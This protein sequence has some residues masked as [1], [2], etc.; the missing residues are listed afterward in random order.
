MYLNGFGNHHQ[1]EA[2]KG[3]LPMEQNSPQQC[4]FGLYAEQLSGTAFTRQR[5]MNFYS[6]LYRILPSVAAGSFQL[7]PQQIVQPYIGKQ[8]PDPQRWSPMPPSKKAQDFVDSLYHVAGHDTVNVFLYHCDKTMNMR[9]FADNDGELLIVPYQ[10]AIRL[11]TELGQLSIEPG[12]IAVIPRGIKFRV[13]LDTPSAA[14]YVCENMAE[15]LKLPQLG[16]IGANGLAHARHF[17]YPV[18]AYEDVSGEV[19]LICKSGQNCWQGSLGQSPLNVVAWHGNYAPY[20]YHLSLYNTINTVSYDHCDPSIFTVLTSESY[21][22]GT[23][24]LDFVIFPERWMVAEHSFRPPYYH[25]NVMSELMGL[26]K[27][28]YDAKDEGFA[29]GGISI[30]NAM[31]P[32]GPDRQSFEAASRKELKPERYQNTL[33]F[34]FETCLPWKITQQAMEAAERQENYLSCWQDLPKLFTGS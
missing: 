8:S 3:A 24:N 14:G 10:G 30:H 17:E 28:C 7:S 32:H 19:E 13:Q 34:M 18:A 12:W 31:T 15:P 29:P 27:G 11:Q 4:P 9:F 1:T 2:L 26:V 5:H 25:R 23:A 21:S 33:A 6:W 16:P 20:R 22:P